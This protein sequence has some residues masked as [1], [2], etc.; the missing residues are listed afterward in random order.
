MIIFWAMPEVILVVM[1]LLLDATG[2]M[3]FLLHISKMML[4]FEIVLSVSL[5]SYAKV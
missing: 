1:G 2:V 4:T 3:I 5:I